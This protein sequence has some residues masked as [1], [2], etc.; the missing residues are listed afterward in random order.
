MDDIGFTFAGANFCLC[1]PDALAEPVS[2]LLRDVEHTD[3]SG[4]EKAVE[5]LREG[6]GDSFRIISSTS[7]SDLLARA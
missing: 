2:L 3:G 4:D 1:Y 7:Q 5:I 6:P